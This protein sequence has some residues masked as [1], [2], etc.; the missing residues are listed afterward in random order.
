MS[1]NK[2]GDMYGAQTCCKF[3]F[4]FSCSSRMLRWCL[5]CISS[6]CFSCSLSNNTH[7]QF[8]I[9]IIIII[10]TN[11]NCLPMFSASYYK[12]STD[13]IIIQP[14]E[15]SWAVFDLTESK[16][17]FIVNLDLD[18][19]A[20]R[21]VWIRGCCQKWHHCYSFMFDIAVNFRFC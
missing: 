3:S 2:S 9:I 10:I 7:H 8:T 14:D 19:L 17:R 18:S 6:T 12:L 15:D 1:R 21:M 16:F 20:N 4:N 13:S 11:I 5:H